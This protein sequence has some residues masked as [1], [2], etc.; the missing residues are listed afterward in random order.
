[1]RDG[2]EGIRV[3]ADPDALAEKLTALLLDEVERARMGANARRRAAQFDW[4]K[5]AERFEELG[6]SAIAETDQNG[7]RAT[8]MSGPRE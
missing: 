7:P 5:I 4:A 8:P 2:I 3:Q 6:W 1:M